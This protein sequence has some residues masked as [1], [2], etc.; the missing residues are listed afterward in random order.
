MEQIMI[1]SLTIIFSLTIL[2]YAI[3]KIIVNNNIYKF[4]ETDYVKIN[5]D[6]EKT[7]LYAKVKNKYSLYVKE[8][9]NANINITTFVEEV[10]SGL[11]YKDKT[12]LQKL[13]S[14]KNA[15]STTILLG[16]LGTFIGLSMM[17]LSINTQDLINSLP[18]T[19]SSMQ[20]A[21]ITSIFGIVTSI[22]INTFMENKNCEYIL[23]QLMLK[24]ENLLTA[25]I[26]HKKSKEIDTKIEDVKNTI[27]HISKS[28]E[29]IERFDQIS[30]DLNE[31]NNQFISGIE[32]LKELLYGSQSSIEVFD[33]D[34]RKL[35]KQF[36]ILNMKFKY[37]FDKYDGVEAV[38]QEIL[39]N[40]SSNTESIKE[41]T[42]IQGKIKEY[43][44]DAVAHLGV[45]ERSTQD[46]LTKLSNHEK[47][48]LEFNHEIIEDKN[49][50]ESSVDKLSQSITI[51]SFELNEKLEGIFEIVETYKEVLNRE[52][53]ILNEVIYDFSTI[54]NDNSISTNEDPEEEV[55]VGEINDR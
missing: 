11:T 1:N 44:R 43:V 3:Y 4:I 48:M 39:D 53:S 15:S 30:K 42:V 18:N 28:I 35:D 8:N 6:H 22:V 29:S 10:C 54:I 5:T 45:Y 7:E 49:K 47:E 41:S 50:L 36:S 52:K 17:L 27:K 40:I 46:L 51:S 32:A 37:L 24:I 14:L 2:T 38:N 19:I 20:T 9:Q 16:V 55:T 33:Q 13:R 31:F 26:T 25:E 34:I 23:T 21:F 12:I